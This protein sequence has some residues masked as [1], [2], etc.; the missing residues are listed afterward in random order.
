[1]PGLIDAHAHIMMNSIAMQVAMTA[2]LRYINLVAARAAKEMLQRGFT[3]IRD[4]GGPSL[5]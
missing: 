4:L 1:M 2:D 3:T 5:C